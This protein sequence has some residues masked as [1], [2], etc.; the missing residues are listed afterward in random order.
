MNRR[1]PNGRSMTRKLILSLAVLGLAWAAPQDK[2]AGREERELPSYGVARRGTAS[3]EDA[4][5]Q[6]LSMA[7]NQGRAKIAGEVDDMSFDEVT[8]QL[9]SLCIVD[10]AWGYSANTCLRRD[11]LA[12]MTCSCLGCRPGLLTGVCGMTRRYA[13]REMMYQK[14][15][16][17]GAP[18]TLVSGSELLSVA[19]RVSRR[20]EPRRDVQLTNDEIH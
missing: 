17:P 4:Y 13:H 2:P 10:P 11:V 3:V 16:P 18:A 14:V 5:R 8:A 12:Y 6:F 19:T 1:T 7:V 15:I 9:E 20:A